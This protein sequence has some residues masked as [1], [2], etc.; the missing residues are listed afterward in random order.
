[1]LGMM[2]EGVGDAGPHFFA[3]GDETVIQIEGSFLQTVEIGPTPRQ[4][5]SL[6]R[7]PANSLE[8]IPHLESSLAKGLRKYDIAFAKTTKISL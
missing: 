5:A 2:L 7:N 4:N 6:L 1:M 3:G 8:N